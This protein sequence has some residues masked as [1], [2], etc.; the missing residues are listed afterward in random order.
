MLSG[1]LR[2]ATALVGAGCLGLAYVSHYP[3]QDDRFTAGTGP[4]RAR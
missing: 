1:G 3:E 4:G 2:F